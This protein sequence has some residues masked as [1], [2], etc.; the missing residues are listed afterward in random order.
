MGVQR[1]MQ[2]RCHIRSCLSSSEFPYHASRA[3]RKKKLARGNSNLNMS[4]DQQ[5]N[6]AGTATEDPARLKLYMVLGGMGEM[7]SS[8]CRGHSRICLATFSPPPLFSLRLQR[9][10]SQWVSESY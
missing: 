7:V 6:L 5:D 3:A 2:R 9:F 8:H 1:D 4:P 10:R